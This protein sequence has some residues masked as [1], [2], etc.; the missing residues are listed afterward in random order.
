MTANS[1]TPAAAE[2][3]VIRL[4]PVALNG[5]KFAESTKNQPTMP[6]NASGRN[7]R[8]TVRFWNQAMCRMPRRLMNAGIHRP[9][10]AMPK[11]VHADGLVMSNND[12]TYITHDETM[13]ALPAHAVTQ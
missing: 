13:A 4:P 7:F 9:V 2:I 5:P 11:F 12:S 1:A 6:T 10:I 3:A 8:I